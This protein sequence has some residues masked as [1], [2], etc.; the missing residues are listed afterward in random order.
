MSQAAVA[1]VVGISQPAYKKIEDGITVFTKYMPEIEKALGIAHAEVDV[2][3]GSFPATKG[4]RDL[5]VFVGAEGGPGE[6]VVST[7]PIEIVER[8][9]YV[10]HVDDAYAVLITGESM[11]PAFKP[12]TYAIVNPRLPPHRDTEMIFISGDDESGEFKATI[13]N[14]VR[15]TQEEWLVEQYNPQLEFTLPRAVWS[16]AVRVVGSY[17]R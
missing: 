8:P 2:K 6:M 9:W 1:A 3:D 11:S 13:K 17:K 5:P 12:G 16:K 7:R 15:W 10:E 14:L 4:Y